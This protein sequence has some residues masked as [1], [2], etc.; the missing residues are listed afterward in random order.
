MK[1]VRTALSVFEAVTSR[2]PV[3]LSALAREV[4]LPKATVQ[5]SLAALADAGWL[6][7][8]LLDPGRWVVSARFAVLTD[9][10]PL[11]QTTRAVARPHL[12]RL[13]DSTGETVG[14]FTIDG[15]HMVLLDG[16]ESTQVVRVVE[17]ETGPL[18]IHVSAAGRAMLA[19]LPREQVAVIIDR[20]ARRGL[21]QY[22]DRSTVDTK[23]LGKR[24]D[25]ARRRGYAT[26][27][28]EYVEDLCGI[29]AAVLGPGGAPA[30]GVALLAPSYRLSSKEADRTG[31]AVA[32]CATMIGADLRRSA[33]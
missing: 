14:L 17:R 5:R 25:E 33:L 8:D 29:G 3:G 27:D 10:A 26:V 16:I 20:L 21:A 18:P 24:I 2:Q 28:R 12:A 23:A 11:V 30:A 22:T 19:T 31:R 6:V 9:A 15:D 13:R 1:S 32:E 7:Q 4:G